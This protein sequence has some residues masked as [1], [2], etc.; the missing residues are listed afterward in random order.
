MNEFVHL[1]T[2]TEYSLLYS[3]A[4]IKDLA[5]YAQEQGMQALGTADFSMYGTISIYQTLQQYGLKHVLGQSV[6]VVHQ[7]HARQQP[8]EL[9][10]IAKDFTGYQSL[11]TLASLAATQQ[12]NDGQTVN[13]WKEVVQHHHGLLCLTG[14]SQGPIHAAFLKDATQAVRAVK[15]LQEWFGK[16]DVYVELQHNGYRADDAVIEAH[17]RIALQSQAVAVATSPIRHRHADDVRLLDVLQAIKHGTT[18]AQEAAARNGQTSEFRDLAVMQSLFAMYP[19]AL[20]TTLAI[21]EKTQLTIPLHELSLPAFPL[22]NG[23]TEYGMLRDLADVGLH[24]RNLAQKPVYEKRLQH[25]L[26]VIGRLGFA[27][28]FLIVWDFIRFS[29]ENKISVGPGRGSAAGSL[30]AY[31]LYI[32]DVDPVRYGLLFERFLN[33]E[34]VNWP[35]IDVDF[36]TDRRYEVIRYVTQRYGEQHVAQIGTLGTL[37]ARAA[38]RD[39]ARVLELSNTETNAI[40]DAL[41]DGDKLQKL[42]QSSPAARRVVTLSQGIEGLPRHTS[43]HAAGVVISRAPLPSLAPVAQGVEG[44]FVTQYSMEDIEALGLLKMDFLGLRTLTICDRALRYVE[45]TRNITISYDDIEMDKQ[46]SDLLASGD[47]DGCFQLESS[48]VKQV[49]RDLRP[50]E[51]EDLI[52]VISLYRPGPMEQIS[53][54]IK[55]RRGDIPVHYEVVQLEPILRSTYGIIVYQEQIM[56]IAH[57]MAGF[58]LGQADVLRRAVG[59]KKR[60]VLD[61]ARTTFVAG[62]LQNGFSDAIANQVYD[63]IVRFAD[64]G[65][66]RSHAAAYAILALRTA[67]LKAHFRP[68]FMA[69]LMTD[70][71]S[72]PD[73]VAH[74]VSSCRQAGIQVL[75]PDVNQ[76]L[77]DCTAERTEHGDIA[78]RF[79]LS[80]IKN[81]GVNAI[82]AILHDREAKGPYRSLADLYHRIDARALTRRVLE[83][84]IQAG[85]LDSIGS[86]RKGMLTLLET[87]VQM[88]REGA[89]LSLLSDSDTLQQD[90]EMTNAFAFVDD[91]Q[92]IDVWEQDLLGMV[93][94]RDPFEDVRVVQKSLGVSPIAASIAQMGQDTRP[95]N[96]VFE[97]VAKVSQWRTVRTKKGEM[98]AFLSLED[99]SGKMEVVLFPS[100]F[101]LMKEIPELHQI[102]QLDVRKDLNADHHFIALKMKNVS[103]IH[104]RVQRQ[105]LYIKI[106]ERLEY[107]R[108]ALLALRKHLLQHRGADEVV[109]IYATGARRLLDRVNVVVSDDLLAVIHDIAG[110]DST[111]IVETTNRSGEKV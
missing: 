43:T 106:D 31:T 2:Y 85:A 107:D 69:A 71:F 97:V 8:V 63:L 39:V 38:V 17:A 42:V 105:R 54:F 26:E 23:Q 12:G 67:Y 48:G 70:S 56:Q 82:D 11:C 109:L 55:A 96:N 57:T 75:L 3:A 102:V 14:G 45:Q 5:K 104:N 84:L 61:E 100:V 9:L 65:F 58:S 15:Q 13:T 81:V 86:S 7:R 94:S 53:T 10:L 88:P 27:G 35:D 4:R 22:P 29:R 93:I 44:I 90:E 47:T 66:N 37:A 25:E 16:D 91:K 76:S 41:D 92:E 36:E 73:K 50:T 110:P 68:E 103:E 6:F 24:Q 1:R 64:Y 60:E 20:Q 72:R 87:L 21:A 83:C 49:L 18:M 111:R 95:K 28:Y 108:T 40:V 30:V 78:V 46:T 79:G 62:C 74:Y 52:A 19:E 80:A 51:L 77:S 32:T 89:Q 33:P 99:S 98:M 59:K 34:R 101:R